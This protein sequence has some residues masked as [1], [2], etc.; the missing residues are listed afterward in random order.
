MQL[1]LSRG[2]AHDYFDGAFASYMVNLFRYRKQKAHVMSANVI[3]VECFGM[4]RKNARRKFFEYALKTLYCILNFYSLIHKIKKFIAILNP[5]VKHSPIIISLI[6]AL[7]NF[8]EFYYAHTSRDLHSLSISCGMVNIM[9]IRHSSV[10]HK[11]NLEHVRNF[12]LL[13][14]PLNYGIHRMNERRNGSIENI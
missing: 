8:K 5:P 13:I 12:F 2:L 6:I 9:Y 7:K 11:I 1:R 4:S 10:P 3:I 14:F